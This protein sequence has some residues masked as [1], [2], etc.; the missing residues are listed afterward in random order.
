MKEGQGTVIILA[1]GLIFG[2]LLGISLHLRDINR[3]LEK[4]EQHQA[5]IASPPEK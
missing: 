3:H 2:T 5:V 1:L 4:I